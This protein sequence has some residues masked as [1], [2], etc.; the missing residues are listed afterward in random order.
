MKEK[1]GFTVCSDIQS[2]L[3]SQL[4][5]G[6]ISAS[7]GLAAADRPW[8]GAPTMTVQLSITPGMYG[9]CPAVS[10]LNFVIRT[11]VT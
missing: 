5:P 9:A 1:G 6:L 3:P 7:A 11:G 4:I 2:P 10:V 8:A